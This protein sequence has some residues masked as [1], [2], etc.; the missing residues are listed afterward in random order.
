MSDLVRVKL[1]SGAEASV[2]ASFAESHNLK[3]LDRPALRH[4]RALR[5]KYPVDL[6]G[7]ALDAALDEAGLSKSGSADEK[8]QRLSDHQLSVA[9]V[10]GTATPTTPVGESDT[11]EEDSK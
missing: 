7:A 10:V 4:G 5:T 9:P 2:G 8:R 1:D 6:K 11:S 3:M